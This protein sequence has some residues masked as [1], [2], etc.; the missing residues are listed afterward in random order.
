MYV[1]S[2]AAA[3]SN[4]PFTR[5]ASPGWRIGLARCDLLAGRATKPEVVDRDVG[6]GLYRFFEFLSRWAPFLFG[7]EP[8]TGQERRARAGFA[9]DGWLHR[10]EVRRVADRQSSAC[11]FARV[12]WSN[13][14]ERSG[15]SGR[16]RGAGVRRRKFGR[17]VLSLR[18]HGSGQWGST[19][20]G[21]Y[22][23]HGRSPFSHRTRRR[24]DHSTPP[25]P[26]TSRNALALLLTAVSIGCSFR[27]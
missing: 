20:T 12:P 3:F 17:M 11:R 23:F 9:V 27:G 19:Y 1:G 10:L 4:S 5:L 15:R 25:M 24:Q 8:A 13:P 22:R 26:M 2:S 16:S 18:K 14:T 7:D 6:F 21:P